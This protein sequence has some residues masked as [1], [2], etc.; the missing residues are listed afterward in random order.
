M[1]TKNTLLDGDLTLNGD[2]FYYNY[3]DYQI[4]EIVD[5]T[6]LNQNYD[7]HA[8]GAELEAT[9]EP[10]PG[11]RFNFSGGWEDTEIAKGQSAVDLMDRTAGHPGWY[12]TKPFINEASNCI[13]PAIV[14]AYLLPWRSGSALVRAPVCFPMSLAM[15]R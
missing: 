4:S 5:R 1:G 13:F 7:A 8:K 6:A 9:W 3:E 12:V 10:I 11:L 2:V 14:A 15:I